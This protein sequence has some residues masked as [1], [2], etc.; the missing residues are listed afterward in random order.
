MLGTIAGGLPAL[1]GVLLGLRLY[2][3]SLFVWLVVLAATAAAIGMV[4]G[5]RWLLRRRPVLGCGLINAAY[6]LALLT[7]ALATVLVTYVVL[8]VPVSV[9]GDPAVLQ[10]GSDDLKHLKGAFAGAVSAFVAT[11]WLKDIGEAKGG[12]W[13]SSHFQVGMRAAYE[14]RKNDIPAGSAAEQAM[15]SDSV[16]DGHGKLDWGLRDRYRRARIVEAVLN[17]KPS[18]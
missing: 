9:L 12:F 13:P 17:P 6:A 11:V 15:L 16:I 7:T 14:A 3:A 10:P 1:I 5:G 18:T 2:T 4:T 8:Q